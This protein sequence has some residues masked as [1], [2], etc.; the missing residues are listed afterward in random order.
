MRLNESFSTQTLLFVSELNELG[1][2][3]LRPERQESRK[4]QTEDSPAG[5]AGLDKGDLI[6]DFGDINHVNRMYLQSIS[7]IVSDA[8]GK[9]TGIAV[10][11]LS[12]LS[13]Y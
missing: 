10:T 9:R 11:L 6:T 13:H 3:C 5:L 12:N 4:T 7:E 8:A 1:R 2:K